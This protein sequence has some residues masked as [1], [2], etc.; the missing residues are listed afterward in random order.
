MDEAGL[1]FRPYRLL[2]LKGILKMIP[3]YSRPAMTQIWEPENKFRKW[4]EI[5]AQACGAQAYL[6]I[7][8]VA[9]A[10]RDRE[11]VADVDNHQGAV[12]HASEGTISN[13]LL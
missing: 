5:E 13:C 2:M 12:A 7:F 6:G 4:L 1:T 8:P 11:R 9:A 3:R 10:K